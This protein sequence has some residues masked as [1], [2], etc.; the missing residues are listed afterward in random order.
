[1]LVSTEITPGSGDAEW[2]LVGATVA[3][4][5]DAVGVLVIGLVG[6]EVGDADTSSLW[7]MDMLISLVTMGID[8]LIFPIGMLIS[9]SSMGIEISI[10]PI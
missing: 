8:I 4:G 9:L 5:D 2:D 1:M 7:I 6:L 10:V 3:T